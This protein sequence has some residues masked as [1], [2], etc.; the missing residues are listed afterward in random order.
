MPHIVLLGDSTLDNAA[1]T[2]GG[3]AVVTQLRAV[4]PPGWEATLVAV[5]GAT[6]RTLGP[7][8][9]AIPPGATHLLLS[10][11]G[12]D[13]LQHAGL[14]G[15]PA[16]SVGHA[17]GLVADAVAEFERDYRAVL[18]RVLARG[19]P[20]VV[21]TIY[22]GCFPDPEFQRFASTA[23]ALFDD[24]ILHV[25]RERALATI[26]LRQVCSADEDYVNCIEPSVVG[27]GKIARAIGAVMV[28]R[29]GDVRR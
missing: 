4:L 15:E 17:L 16:A 25:A 8:L 12:N 13:A 22:E 26:D 7:Q 23:A 21:C 5:D 11:G 18:G 19:L 28:G 29:M 1:Y 2:D 24:A 20:T 3:P 9:D 10:V 6:T 14:Y 27:G